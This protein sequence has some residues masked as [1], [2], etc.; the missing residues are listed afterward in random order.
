VR[1]PYTFTLPEGLLSLNPSYLC[2]LT[3][4]ICVENKWSVAL[5]HLRASEAEGFDPR[6]LASCMQVRVG[7]VWV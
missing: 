2:G 4:Q 3:R 7:I 1:T 6:L 5:T